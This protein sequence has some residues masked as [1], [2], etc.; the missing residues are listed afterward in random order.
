[1]NNPFTYYPKTDL[2]MLQYI[3]Q[4]LQSINK[5]AEFKIERRKFFKIYT[6]NKYL[7]DANV[8][9]IYY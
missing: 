9:K 6:S 5:A 2:Q 7:C 8:T 4:H 1:M 3:L